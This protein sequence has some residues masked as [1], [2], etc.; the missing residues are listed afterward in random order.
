MMK[1]RS[2]FVY[3]GIVIYLLL[4]FVDFV[5]YKLP[6][7]IYMLIACLGIT[8]VLIGFVKDFKKRRSNKIWQK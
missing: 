3:I 4:S 2:V 1:K 5:I 6:D 7:Y 8:F